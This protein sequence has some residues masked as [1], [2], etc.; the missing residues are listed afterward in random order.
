MG[1]T[2]GAVVGTAVGGFVVGTLVGRLVGIAV[3]GFVGKVVV[4]GG[5][6]VSEG[7]GVAPGIRVGM[8]VGS[9]SNTG[10]GI[11][12][13]VGDA[14]GGRGGTVVR[15]EGTGVDGATSS[16]GS[17]SEVWL[18]TGVCVDGSSIRNL[19]P[20]VAVG[21]VPA[22]RPIVGDAPGVE[23]LT[24]VAVVPGRAVD[25]DVAVVPGRAVDA[26]VGDAGPW[27]GVDAV[28]VVEGAT[29]GADAP[30]PTLPGTFATGRTGLLPAGARAGSLRS[31]GKVGTGVG[32]VS[33]ATL[34]NGS[35]SGDDDVG[36]EA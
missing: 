35:S 15:V 2:V 16:M 4:V 10:A 17:G 9:G 13:G 20:G 3:G 31:E 30:P 18:G 34:P 23:V 11:R 27:L 8:G 12:V 33:S 29:C 14:P 21:V 36:S 22:V 19:S 5:T 25:A 7:M 26:D 28:L 6:A 1:T 32:S 24:D